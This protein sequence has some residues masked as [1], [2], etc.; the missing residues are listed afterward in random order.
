VCVEGV[1]RLIET[2]DD[3]GRR[4]VPQRAAVE[5]LACQGQCQGQ[6]DQLLLLLA[7]QEFHRLYDRV[8][9]WHEA[10]QEGGPP[11]T[12]DEVRL[13][14]A[15]GNGASLCEGVPTPDYLAETYRSYCLWYCRMMEPA[16]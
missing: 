9:R 8:M 2:T 13:L 5:E 10:G 16:Y 11:L 12:S 15:R 6:I 7:S 14:Q 4:D 3:P 1:V